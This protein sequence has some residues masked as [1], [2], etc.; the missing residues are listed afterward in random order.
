MNATTSSAGFTMKKK[1]AKIP[2]LRN[3]RTNVISS[4]SVARLNPHQNAQ[5]PLKERIKMKKRVNRAGV[6]IMKASI[7]SPG[8]GRL[9]H[10][11]S[12]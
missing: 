10:R 4:S 6:N 2:K 7:G 1:A 9:S 12:M 5:I 8:N 3:P 11:E